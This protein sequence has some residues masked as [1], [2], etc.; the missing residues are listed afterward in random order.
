MDAFRYD[1]FCPLA[2][3]TEVLCHRW[4]LLILRELWIGPQ[5]FSDLKRRLRGVSTSVLS[6]RLA[7]LV[8][9]GVVERRDL[10]PPAATVVYELSED[11]QALRPALI[12]L[13]RWGVR[14]MLPPTPGDHVEPDWLQLAVEAFARVEA[15]PACRLELRVTADD[16][17]A[18][19]RVRGGSDGTRLIDA[20]DDHP[21][22]ASIEAP[23]A[24]VLAMMSGLLPV[25][26]AVRTGAA[27]V[28]GDSQA[29]N[30]LPQLFEMTST[31]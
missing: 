14:R 31:A 23:V 19:V 8:G 12:A 21:A 27:S 11:G 28:A 15:S 13:T 16:R 26:E 3:A 4:T 18:R 22:D 10:P 25:A 30:A 6:D 24:V 20:G 5:R 1:Q 29:A 7:D 17:E 2:R 9:H